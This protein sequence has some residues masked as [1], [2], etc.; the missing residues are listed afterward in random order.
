MTMRDPSKQQVLD[1]IDKGIRKAQKDYKDAAW[2][3][4][5]HGPEYLMTVRIFYSLL[6]LAKKD[7]FT[8]ENR[9]TDLLKWLKEEKSPRVKPRSVPRGS[10]R[11]DICLWHKGK[12]RPRAIIEV[13]RRAMDWKKHTR[14][15]DIDRTAELML[16]G[17]VHKFEFGVLASCIHRVLRNN[18]RNEAERKI[19]DDLQS[20]EQA[21]EE[22]LNSQLGVKLE[23]SGFKLL[24]LKRDYREG[25]GCDDWIWRPIVFTIYRKPNRG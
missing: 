13:K 10:G 4:L 23:P 9:P 20:L 15:T 14:D 3:A 18:N 24:P 7:S 22:K 6:G 2:T 25:E 17:S 19:N 8:L 16:N 5:C 21:I 12:N 1:A 11:I